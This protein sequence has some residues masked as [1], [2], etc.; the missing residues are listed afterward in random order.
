M[1]RKRKASCMR[2]YCLFCCLCYLALPATAPGAQ[3]LDRQT[4]QQDPQIDLLWYDARNLALE[5]K[6]WTDTESFY[7][8][9]PARAKAMVPPNVW[10]LSHHSTGMFVR[11]D[12]D[13]E[14]VHVRW[15]LLRNSPSM[16]SMPVRGCQSVDMY[17]RDPAGPWRYTIGRYK[18]G[19][20][21]TDGENEAHYDEVGGRPCLLYLPISGGVTSV[22]IGIP[23]KASI[24]VPD[25]RDFHQFRPIVFYGTSLTHGGLVSRPGMAMTALVQRRLNVP[26]LNLGFSG[27]GK[28]EPE[29]ASLLAELEPSIYVLDC[30]WNMD[31][32]MVTERA[33]TFVKIVR[34]ARPDTP[35]VL[36]EDSNYRHVDSTP[37]GRA[38]RAVYEKLKA[39]G[40]KH[41]VFLAGK[42]MLGDDFDGTVDGCHLNDLGASRQADF[43][44]Q[45]LAAILGVTIPQHNP[46]GLPPK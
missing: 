13:A 16:T 24:T 20:L 22:E 34:A 3:P 18:S 42:E 21:P 7:D 32:N 35:I 19:K 4:A 23:A 36:A 29:V 43:F 11:F 25:D 45:T 2:I 14:A 38:L 26:V 5:G 12:T 6:G 44:V 28:M 37:R 33:G 40:V 1:D 17:V 46:P 41:L 31:E 8:R 9:L 39:E 15:T 30:L 10:A 27:S